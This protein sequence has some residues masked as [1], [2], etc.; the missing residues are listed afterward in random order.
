M[1]ITTRIITGYGLFIAVLA[2][3]SVFQIYTVIRMQE[4]NQS[5]KDINYEN[6]YNSIQVIQHG[7]LI[8]EYT[9]KSLCLV[10]PESRDS[11]KRKLEEY[12][13]GFDADMEL[14]Q[15]GASSDKE[16]EEIE[17]L[18]GSWD[19][20]TRDLDQIQLD[21]PKEGLSELTP[22]LINDLEMLG[23]QTLSVYKAIMVSMNANM[24]QSLQASHRAQF[25]LVSITVSVLSVT[26]LIS[27]LIVRSI[28][29]PLA[30]LTEGTRAIT[31]GKYFYR[32]DTSRNDEFAQLAK[33]F[34]TMIRR[35]SELDELKK[36]FISHVSHE[37]KAP[38]ASMRET[39]QLLIDR[40]PGPLTDKQKRLLE[41]NLQS[42]DRL[43]TMIRNLLDLTKI[44]AGTMEYELMRQDLVPLVRTAIAA[45]EVQAGEKQVRI[46]TFLPDA[47]VQIK[48][49]SDRIVQVLVNLVGNAVK[50][51]PNGGHVRIRLEAVS[52]IPESMPQSWRSLVAVPEPSECLRLLSIAD[53]GPGIADSDKSRIFEKFHQ[54]QKGKKMAG[55]GV[56][57]GLAICRTIVQVH[58][59][60]VWVEDNPG[61]GSCFFLLLSPGR[62]DDVA[63]RASQPI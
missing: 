57:L 45:F 8:R 52:E 1:K 22:F 12:L 47:P 3:L 24:D 7:D 26:I 37:L 32:L 40:I 6:A 63:L 59:G 2:G 11:Y 9:E 17:R 48:C 50:F 35:L 19:T 41:L 42:G 43:T 36:D 29:K 53:S 62:E 31:E 56:G 5:F 39:V 4:I 10:D 58:R 34:N 38:L 55:Q 30:H 18:K 44:E 15:T 49:D 28:S 54:V 13:E 21:L 60:A 46:E 25:V 27:L 20:F 16:R 23:S 61:G 33:D 51:S 14:L